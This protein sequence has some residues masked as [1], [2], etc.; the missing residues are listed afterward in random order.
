MRA[1][2]GRLLVHV[3]NL[4][5]DPLPA[6][7]LAVAK[8]VREAERLDAH[9]VWRPL[10]VSMSPGGVLRLP[11]ALGMMEECVLRLAD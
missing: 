7:S 10:T 4:C 5:Y 6:I 2:D 3:V 1:A 9:G 11:V 8:P